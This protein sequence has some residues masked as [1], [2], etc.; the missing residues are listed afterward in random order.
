MNLP[1][2][3][4]LFFALPLL[5]AFLTLL[6]SKI[7]K[8]FSDLIANIITTFLLFFSFYSLNHLQEV[9]AVVYKMGGWPP[10]IGITMVYDH[11]SALMVIAIAIVAF[12]VSLF[13]IRFLDQY[14]GRVKFYTLFL[15]M[16]GGMMGIAIT[17]DIFNLFV[18]LEIASI[19][20]YA[21]VAF[22]TEKGGLEAS[23]KYM[24]MGEIASLAIL[25]S[26][27]LLYSRA[28][29]L[30]MA[31][32]ARTLSITGKGHLFWFVAAILLFSFSIKTG[33]F[34]FHSW[35]PDAQTGAPAPVA[36]ILSGSAEKVIGI[37]ALMRISFNVLGLNRLSSPVFFNILIIL[38]LASIFF[39]GIIARKQSDYKRLLAYSTIGQLGY[40]VVG[41]GIGNFWAIA[42][43]LFHIFA[44]AITKSLLFLTAGAVDYNTQDQNID[45]L[46]GLGKTM[47]VTAWSFRLG[48]LSLSGVPP[49]VGFF[50]KLLIII[51]ACQARAYWLAILLAALSV[52]TLAY[53][54]KVIRKVYFTS[55]EIAAREAPFTMR[56]AL[57]FLVI[58]MIAFGFGFQGILNGLIFPATRA[59]LNGIGYARIVFG[60]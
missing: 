44:H 41:F 28:S 52:F 10:P 18:F 15:L 25:F 32:L 56:L 57:L 11:L 40:I 8:G 17:G 39:G 12:G 35:L 27:A 30:N 1:T 34:P 24:V 22:T 53:L 38:G 21:L 43:A 7:W 37:Y 42:G 50:S 23:F 19:S 2:M 29:T 13:S 33:L 36:A 3:L 47:G 9:G 4:P 45:N 26:I 49:F 51:G 55:K 60:G 5:G 6:L 20:S 59:L 46:K 16:T 54:L 31:D 48:T 58:L 14:T